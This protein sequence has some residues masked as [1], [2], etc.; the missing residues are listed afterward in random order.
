MY[1][2]T[3]MWKLLAVLYKPPNKRAGQSNENKEFCALTK[4]S[5]ASGQ[6]EPIFQHRPPAAPP[7]A[8]SVAVVSGVV[9]STRV[10]RFF[11]FVV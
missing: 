2:C 7:P 10:D 1:L 6:P 8:T 3:Y 4:G 9:G 5:S 11:F